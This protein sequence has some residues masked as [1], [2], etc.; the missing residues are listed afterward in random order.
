MWRILL[1]QIDAQPVAATNIVKSITVLHNFIVENEPHRLMTTAQNVQQDQ[2][3][4]RGPVNY[5][6]LQRRRQRATKCA[7]QIREQFMQY[8]LSD[9]GS[10]PWQNDKCFT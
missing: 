8:F 1:R 7:L 2:G 4:S 9:A 10:L 3:Q 5:Q 6:D